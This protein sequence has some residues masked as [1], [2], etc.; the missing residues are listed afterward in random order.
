MPNDLRSQILIEIQQNGVGALT[1]IEQEV[2]RIKASM[3]ALTDAFNAGTASTDEYRKGLAP[4]LSDLKFLDGQIKSLDPEWAA[5]QAKLR[6]MGERDAKAA[7]EGVAA[8]NE[9]LNNGVAAVRNHVQELQKQA[10][11][12]REQI[13]LLNQ[14]HGLN[15]IT[16]KDVQDDVRA[17]SAQTAALREAAIAEEN[18]VRHLEAAAAAEA[19]GYRARRMLT[20]AESAALNQTLALQEAQNKAANSSWQYHRIVAQ[21]GYALG[22]LMQ[23]SGGWERRLMAITNNIQFALAPFGTLGT[24]IGVAATGFA[25]LMMNREAVG[26]YFGFVGEHAHQAAQNISEVADSLRDVEAAKEAAKEKAKPG[27]EVLD[28]KQLY[29]GAVKQGGGGRTAEDTL[30]QVE[31]SNFLADPFAAIETAVAEGRMD[32]RR[33]GIDRNTSRKQIAQRVGD[34]QTFNVVKELFANEVLPKIVNDRINELAAGSGGAA[35]R[36][37][38]E[39]GR[40]PTL[41]ATDQNG[42]L[43][44]PFLA[45]LQQNDADIAGTRAFDEQFEVRMTRASDAGRRRRQKEAAGDKEVDYIV[46]QSDELERE[47]HDRNATLMNAINEK[48]RIEGH[49]QDQ[50]AREAKK[51]AKAAP[52]QNLERDLVNQYHVTPAQ[53]HQIAP[54]VQR[55]MGAGMSQQDAAAAAL[56]QM[57]NYLQHQQTIM[58]RQQAMFEQMNGMFGQASQQL[59]MQEAQQRAFQA[60]ARGSGMPPVL[61]VLPQ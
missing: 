9:G 44:N 45:G 13:A 10:D 41:G 31:M 34:D 11:A 26:E 39:A 50:A 18:F 20:D 56:A 47:M 17:R 48:M 7:S 12:Q 42:L 25:S 2:A 33:F 1:V 38:A 15:V 58:L 5:L 6:E 54:T 59:M 52:R 37:L 3:L 53:A 29:E 43:L 55:G 4:L 51:A 16:T 21:V 46:R 27:Q 19:T 23:T 57:Q 32:L 61:P 49:E 60:R 40:H 28:A 22:D 14:F 36:L 35:E 24:S 8:V 30:R